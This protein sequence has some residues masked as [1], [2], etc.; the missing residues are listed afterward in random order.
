M[1]F[2]VSEVQIKNIE[3]FDLGKVIIQSGIQQKSPLISYLV[4]FS[5]V[6]WVGFELNQRPGKIRWVPTFTGG[7]GWD[8]DVFLYSNEK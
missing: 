4:H 3:A 1:V 2:F 6:S 5:R 8:K 7:G